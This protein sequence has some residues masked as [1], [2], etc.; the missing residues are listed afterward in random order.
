MRTNQKFNLG[1]EILLTHSSN[2]PGDL[3]STPTT[4]VLIRK[5]GKFL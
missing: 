2:L 3:N 5:A 4:Q 1:K